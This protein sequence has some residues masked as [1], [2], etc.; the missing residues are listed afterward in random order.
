MDGLSLYAVVKE[1]SCLINGKIDKINQPE[2]DELILSVRAGGM[3]RRLLLCAAADQCRVHLTDTNPPNPAEAPMFCMLLRR[4]L[5]G[6]RVLDVRQRGLDRVAGIV[7][8]ARDELG[9][10]APFELI[11]EIMGKHS[12]IILVDDKGLVVDSIR[13]VSPFMSS[14]R[15]VLPGVKYLLPPAQDKEDPRE[16]DEVRFFE[17]LKGEGRADKRLSE[18][19]SGL[20][21]AV[22]QEICAAA[23][24]DQPQRLEDMPEADKRRISAFLY[25]LYSDFERGAFE[26]TLI[27]DGDRAVR[28]YPFTPFAPEENLRRMPSMNEAIDEFYAVRAM[29][30]RHKRRSAS[31]AH[32]LANNVERCEK[33]AAL[34]RETLLSEDRMEEYRLMGELILASLHL[35]RKGAKEAVLEDYYSDPP[36]KRIV[37]LDERLSPADNAQK[38]YKKYQKLRAA[39]EQAKTLLREAEEELLY[40][41]GQLDNLEKCTTDAELDELRAELEQEG[42]LRPSAPRGKRQKTPPS[43]PLHYVS[44]DG[45]DIYVGKNNRQND[46]LTLSFAS[47]EDLWLHAK[48]FAGSHVIVKKDGPI[49][50]STIEEA[51]LLA[52]YYSRARGGALVP[53]DYTPRKYVKKPSGAKPGMVIYTTNRTAYVTPDE[54]VVGKLKNIE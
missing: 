9:D 14:V 50:P 47:P 2:R 22:A 49:P 36:Q 27:M 18:I 45:L 33:K 38:Y 37:P 28:V 52:A 19:F 29:R 32:I 7:V 25:K 39:R 4:R 20:A 1:L 40:L 48:G 53:V 8:E 23:L 6:A 15:S 10:P 34:H 11:V 3:N 31:L 30:E 5:M 35:I 41:E 54:S 26:P 51:A 46:A 13:R 17:A 43:K 16:A 24:G 42:Y 12:N 21:P 44:S